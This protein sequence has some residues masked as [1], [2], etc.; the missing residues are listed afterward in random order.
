MI[1]AI[2][3]EQNPSNG[4]GGICEQMIT[5]VDRNENLESLSGSFR[6]CIPWRFIVGNE[7]YCGVEFWRSSR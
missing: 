1:C 3:T 2:G 5:K 4:N 7:E 6:S